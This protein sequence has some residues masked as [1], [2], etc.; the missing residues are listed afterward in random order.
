M[1]LYVSF[2]F[3]YQNVRLQS[4]SHVINQWLWDSISG[5]FFVQCTKYEQNTQEQTCSW[6]IA[7][8]QPISLH[9]FWISVQFSS[10]R[11]C[12]AARPLMTPSSS[13]V[14]D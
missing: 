2:I 12:V 5:H 11:P 4:K 9:S 1:I 3:K 6:Y 7:A 13:L 10:T 14:Y 8:V